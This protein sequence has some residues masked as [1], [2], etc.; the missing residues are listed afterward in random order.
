M[1]T[2]VQKR[3]HR[4]VYM[5]GTCTAYIHMCIHR[6]SLLSDSGTP[7]LSRLTDATA[8]V[9]VGLAARLP[10]HKPMLPPLP[11]FLLYPVPQFYFTDVEM[12]L[13][14][15]CHGLLGLDTEGILGVPA[16]GVCMGI[17]Q[18]LNQRFRD[19]EVK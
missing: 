6:L 10:F 11:P 12:K 7:A 9:C 16:Q 8:R 13:M 14:C 15:V 3:V 5:P 18:K 4:F 17:W 1:Q 2:H 19:S